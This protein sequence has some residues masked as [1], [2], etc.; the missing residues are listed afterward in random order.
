MDTREIGKVL[1]DEKQIDI[2][3]I[4]FITKIILISFKKYWIP[5]FK[6]D[7]FL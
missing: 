3:L 4:F 7:T 6:T 5:F 2:T 1:N